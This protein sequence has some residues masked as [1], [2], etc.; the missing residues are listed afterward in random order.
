MRCAARAVAP[1]SPRRPCG[2]P[3]LWRVLSGGTASIHAA[4]CGRGRATPR[5]IRPGFIR[6]RHP[7][8][9]RRGAGPSRAAAA[10]PLRRSYG[11]DLVATPTLSTR[12]PTLAE[13]DVDPDPE[14]WAPPWRSRSTPP[15]DYLGLPAMSVPCG[16]DDR[17][18]PSAF[19]SPAG[20]SRRRRCCVPRTPPAR[21][22]LAPQVAA[23]VTTFPP[24]EGLPPQRLDLRRVAAGVH[25][26]ID[27][28]G[29]GRGQGLVQRRGYSASL[30]RAGRGPR[31]SAS[32]PRS[33]PPASPARRPAGRGRPA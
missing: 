3:R 6:L 2:H 11:P 27:Q 15:F 21:D 32:P 13:T 19:S 14:N 4:R 5:L 28:R 22:R 25:E 10:P 24:R 18:L 9:L 16:F 26:H 29:S 33:P 20:P 7:P 12:V 8:L 17:G 30:A 1:A 23:P 31:A